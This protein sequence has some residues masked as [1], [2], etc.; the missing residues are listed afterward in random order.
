[1]QGVNTRFFSVCA[2]F[3]LLAKQKTHD[4]LSF[5]KEEKSN[6]V[7]KW[8]EIKRQVFFR[9]FFHLIHKVLMRESLKIST[10]FFMCFSVRKVQKKTEIQIRT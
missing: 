1:M 3:F 10:T 7:Q 8:I 9:S 5:S 6:F 4:K 2:Y